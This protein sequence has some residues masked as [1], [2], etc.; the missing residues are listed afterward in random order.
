MAD[1][2]DWLG[3]YTLQELL[4]STPVTKTKKQMKKESGKRGV[5]SSVLG[6][7]VRMLMALIKLPITVLT[8]IVTGL[9]RAVAE[10]ARLPIRLVGAVVSPWR[11]K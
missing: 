8:K 2:D 1:K 4:G 11:N 9:G 3:G 7:P 6:A 10:V 5:V